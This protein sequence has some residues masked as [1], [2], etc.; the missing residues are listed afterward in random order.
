M[1]LLRG[2]LVVGCASSEGKIWWLSGC[3]SSEGKVW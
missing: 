3:A 2:N 1:L